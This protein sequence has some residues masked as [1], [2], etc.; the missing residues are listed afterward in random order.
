MPASA[1]QRLLLGRKGAA[2]FL[3]V[4]EDRVSHRSLAP[5][6]LNTL[7]GVERSSLEYDASVASRP[8]AITE[9][10]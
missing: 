10:P 6:S 9:P 4:L 3:V 2:Q 8:M 5:F 7:I 1:F